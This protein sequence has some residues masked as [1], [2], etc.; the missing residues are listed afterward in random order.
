MEAEPGAEA[1][2]GEEGQMEEGEEELPEAAV[3]RF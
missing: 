3:P 1:Q 2:E